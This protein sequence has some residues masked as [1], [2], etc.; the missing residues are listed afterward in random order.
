MI[1]GEKTVTFTMEDALISPLTFSILSG[2]NLEDYSTS[3]MKVHF[4]ETVKCE[5]AGEVNIKDLLPE[6][7]DNTQTRGIV[8]PGDEGTADYYKIYAYKID[9]YGN[10][11]TPITGDM[12]GAGETTDSDTIVILQN[13]NFTKGEYYL[14]DCY[15]YANGTKIT[16]GP[17]DFAGSYYV[18]AD[19]LFRREADGVD[20]AAQFIIPHGK[21]QSQYTF[22]MASSGDPSTFSFTIDA[23]P[24]YVQFDR[25][26]KVQ[27][28]LNVIDE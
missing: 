14:I 17:E 25:S 18:E 15:V 24:D 3:T 9:E 1:K 23:F 16:V 13:T 20:M 12:V 22:T 4:N 28:A 26:R 27:F 8:E 2:A 11:G 21:V 19:T 10:I 6:V 7:S 5:K